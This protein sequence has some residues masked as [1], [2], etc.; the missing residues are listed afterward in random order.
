MFSEVLPIWSVCSVGTSVY[1]CLEFR[2]LHLLSEVVFQGVLNLKRQIEEIR[3]T[4]FTEFF[5]CL[6]IQIEEFRSNVEFIYALPEGYFKL[7]IG[8]AAAAVKHE[9]HIRSRIY[10]LQP[11]YI[12]LGRF[13]V[14]AVGAAYCYRN[15]AAAALLA[16]CRRHRGISIHAPRA[17]GDMC[18]GH[19]LD[20]VTNF[21]PRSPC[22]GRL[23][24]TMR[25][26]IPPE[27]HRHAPRAGGDLAEALYWS[28]RD[29][30]H[31][32]APRAGGDNGS[33]AE[34]ITREVGT[35]TLPVR[36]VTTRRCCMR[37]L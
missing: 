16:E 20:A 2:K 25:C 10:L 32:H 19:S 26:F 37:T 36:G 11:F 1:L 30:R 23:A 28:S 24:I 3:M 13:L 27:R 14:K 18:R 5:H 33:G 17:G 6:I 21:N 12:Q 31:R 9:R 15:R 7:I 29:W 4:R 8:Y 35:G 34:D 22:G